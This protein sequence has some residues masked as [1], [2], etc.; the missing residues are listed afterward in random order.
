[1][2]MKTLVAMALIAGVAISALL[3][4]F[5]AVAPK[6]SLASEQA[7]SISAGVIGKQAPAALQSPDGAGDQ[8]VPVQ[9]WTVLAAGGAAGIGLVLFLVRIALGRV[10]PPPPQG[11]A[12]H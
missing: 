1:M 6:T 8:R 5:D 4:A 12:H 3:I 9:L 7:P 11:E 10:K 2:L